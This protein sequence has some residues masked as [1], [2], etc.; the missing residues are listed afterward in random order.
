MDLKIIVDNEL[1]RLSGKLSRMTYDR[2]PKVKR[3]ELLLNHYFYLGNLEK[4]IVIVMLD[5]SI[6]Q[7]DN[8]LYLHQTAK[9]LY[10][11]DIDVIHL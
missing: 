3:P 8:L 9:D 6:I 7:D 5:S 10:Y 11:P 2:I 1:D 4:E